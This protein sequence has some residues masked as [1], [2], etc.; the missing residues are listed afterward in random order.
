MKR[1]L[2]IIGI[3][4]IVIGIVCVAYWKF[5]V[6][7]QRNSLEVIRDICASDKSS[8]DLT[9]ITVW[10]DIPGPEYNDKKGR[11]RIYGIHPDITKAPHAPYVYLDDQGREVL[12]IPNRPVESEKEATEFSRKQTEITTGLVADAPLF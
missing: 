4:L 6:R 1:M 5:S 9:S 8:G 2:L 11:A 12:V 7:D 10:R 3:I